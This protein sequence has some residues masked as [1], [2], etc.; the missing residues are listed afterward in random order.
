MGYPPDMGWGNPPDLGWGNPP[1]DLGWGTLPLRPGMGY[2]PQ[3]PG[4]GYPPMGWGTLPGPEMGYPDRSCIA[5]TCYAA[6]SMPLAFT[7]ED[8]LVSFK[9]SSAERQA[10]G[11][12]N[13]VCD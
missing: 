4:M 10:V 1:L 9:F 8:F 11:T 12:D 7:Q 5:S 2:P 6:G 3:E 13:V